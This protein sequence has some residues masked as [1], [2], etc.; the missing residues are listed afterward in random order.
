M[1]GVNALLN[2]PKSSWEC[3]RSKPMALWRE[4]DLDNGMAKPRL[5][6]VRANRVV[7]G[8]GPVGPKA[9]ARSNVSARLFSTEKYSY[10]N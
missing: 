2:P 9:A 6:F 7:A 5:V 4:G 3:S 10:R 8:S 1:A